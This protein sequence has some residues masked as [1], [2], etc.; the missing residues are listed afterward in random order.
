MTTTTEPFV[1]LTWDNI[2]AE[3]YETSPFISGW[4]WCNPGEF[5]ISYHWQSPCVAVDPCQTSEFGAATLWEYEACDPATHPVVI[6]D[7]AADPRL[8]MPTLVAVGEPPLPAA[9]VAAPVALVATPAA[10]D[11][12]PAT[13]VELTLVVAASLVVA[14]GST[15][16]AA[17][18]RR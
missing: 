11:T 12:L 15:I 2:T 10:T 4:P 1:P 5:P 14:A 13:G 3:Q 8:P 17:T 7:G 6:A 9:L 18:R 16:V